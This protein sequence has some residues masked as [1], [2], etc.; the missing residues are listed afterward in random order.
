MMHI[1]ALNVMAFDR[2]KNCKHHK[3][4]RKSVVV[5][6]HGFMVWP[7]LLDLSEGLFGSFINV[8]N[9]GKE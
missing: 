2:K 7:S 9:G 1:V 3:K 4:N 6:Q 8:N 5:H